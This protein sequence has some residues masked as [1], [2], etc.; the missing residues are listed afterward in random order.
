PLIPD[1]MHTFRILLCALAFA[2]SLAL[3][4]ARA[5]ENS[6][7]SPVSLDG[8]WQFLL[9][10][11]ED[12]AD[13][14]GKFYAE[15]FDTSAFKPIPVPSNWTTHGFEEPHYVNGTKSEGFYL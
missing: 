7:P 5:A 15:G 8:E 9:Q 3:T 13:A 2:G 1:F 4:P 11:D 14:L 6:V 12:A 10:P